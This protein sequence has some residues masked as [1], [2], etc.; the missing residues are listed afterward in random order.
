MNKIPFS[1]GEEMNE[2]VK[3]HNDLNTVP[4]KR[5]NSNEMDLFFAI[6]AK[7]RDKGTDTV[8][9]SFDQ[10]R[11][12]SNYKPTAIKR[13]VNDL[14]QTYDK[15]LNLVY[16]IE[17]DGVLEKFVLFT[18]FKID[19]NNKIV[20]ITINTKFDYILNELTGNFTRFELQEFTSLNSSYSKTMY[21]LLKQWRTIGVKEWPIE[22]FRELLDI[23]KSYPMNKI[24]T[25]V[26]EPIKKELS[27][28]FKRLKIEKIKKGQGNKV[29]AL[30]FSF[31]AESIPSP[32]SRYKKKANKKVEK[33]PEWLENSSEQT[34]D[35]LMGPEKAFEF[36]IRLAKF[37]GSGELDLESIDSETIKEFDTNYGEGTFQK[38]YTNL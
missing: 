8:T 28:Y 17:K 29:V 3:Y 1:G 38:L 20:D 7:M 37:R 26:L 5:F 13:F 2:I 30:K 14:V 21:R 24:D 10:L 19:S 32:Q 34:T 27:P 6:C 16:T 33:L 4:F 31:L 15:Y 18:G 25:K 11:Y 9:F 36:I 12:L 22:S 35:E 23:P